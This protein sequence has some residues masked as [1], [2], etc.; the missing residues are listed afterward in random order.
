MTEQALRSRNALQGR[1]LCRGSRASRLLPDRL[2]LPGLWLATLMAGLLPVTRRAAASGVP[3]P[4][5]PAATS[6]TTP[7][8]LQSHE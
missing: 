5:A 8:Q 2:A 3:V 6:G 1:F 7:C 4:G